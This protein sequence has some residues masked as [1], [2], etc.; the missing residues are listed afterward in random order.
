MMTMN[1]EF[2]TGGHDQQ[3]RMHQCK[4]QKSQGECDETSA[5]DLLPMKLVMIAWSEERQKQKPNSEGY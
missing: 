2:Q 3:E 1:H 5:V 4:M